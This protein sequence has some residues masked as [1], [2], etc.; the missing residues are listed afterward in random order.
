MTQSEAPMT[1]PIPMTDISNLK[2]G[3]AL[4]YEQVMAL[5][6]G[7]VFTAL[8]ACGGSAP[9]GHVELTIIRSG[10]QFLATGS[11]HATHV[12]NQ[13]YWLGHRTHIL[14]SGWHSARLESMPEPSKDQP[15]LCDRCGTTY[16]NNER[17]ACAVRE[18]AKPERQASEIEKRAAAALENSAYGAIKSWVDKLDSCD[19]VF[20]W[21]EELARRVNYYREVYD[22]AES[23]GAIE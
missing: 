16:K 12:G 17:H 11:A 5:P 3:D 4:T 13:S 20:T 2:P 6:D 15:I 21:Y 14:D 19:T 8:F 22:Y 10:K 18:P 1:N 23:I 7:A 9:D